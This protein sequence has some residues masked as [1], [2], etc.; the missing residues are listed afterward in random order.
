MSF[1]NKKANKSSSFSLHTSIYPLLSL[2]FLASEKTK[3]LK[4][5]NQDLSNS[6]EMLLSEMLE[7]QCSLNPPDDGKSLE[8]KSPKE[9]FSSS[10]GEEDDQKLDEQEQVIDE[11]QEGPSEGPSHPCGASPFEDLQRMKNGRVLIIGSSSIMEITSKD[12]VVSTSDEPGPMDV[13]L[14]STVRVLQRAVDAMNLAIEKQDKIEMELVRRA[15]TN[16]NLRDRIDR[17]Y[18]R[19]LEQ[20]EDYCLHHEP[21][22]N[23]VL[24]VGPEESELMRERNH[25]IDVRKDQDERIKAMSEAFHRVRQ[26]GVPC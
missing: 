10:E 13:F 21:T 15:H 14:E 25:L 26:R 16:I 19:R 7:E 3:R 8:E 1:S 17:L 23:E 12:G 20:G 2:S 6:E 9:N 11:T 5:E 24:E 22:S 18:R 4:M